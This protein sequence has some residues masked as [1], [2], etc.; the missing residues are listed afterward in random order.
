MS[1][2]YLLLGV[3]KDDIIKGIITPDGFH[4]FSIYDF[5][6]IVLI[7]GKSRDY[8]KKHGMTFAVSIPTSW[9]SKEPWHWLYQTKRGEIRHQPLA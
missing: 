9:R 4:V 7:G 3:G 5:M 2:V 1:A 6:Q 8:V